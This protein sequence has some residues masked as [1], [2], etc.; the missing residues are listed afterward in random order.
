MLIVDRLVLTYWRH[1]M[2][3]YVL[4]GCLA[5]RFE[6]KDVGVRVGTSTKTVNALID[7]FL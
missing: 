4:T 3:N 1:Q 6:G 7:L 2:R 5:A